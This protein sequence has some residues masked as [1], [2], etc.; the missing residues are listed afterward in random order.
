MISCTGNT[1]DQSRD[2]RARD[3][4]HVRNGRGER[5]REEEEE[6]HKNRG[7][8]R[9]PAGNPGSERGQAANA[10]INEVHFRELDFRLRQRP[11]LFRRA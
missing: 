9:K 6:G 7:E 1:S 8:F 4:E 5:E 10:T 11:L 3:I 2:A